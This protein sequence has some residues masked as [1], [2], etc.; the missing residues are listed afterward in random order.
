MKIECKLLIEILDKLSPIVK[1]GRVKEQ[2]PFI[3][4]HDNQLIAHS[5][6]CYMSIFLDHTFDNVV[7]PFDKTYSLLKGFSPKQN[8][9]FIQEG[10]KVKVNYSA[11]RKKTAAAIAMIEDVS[12]QYLDPFENTKWLPVPRDFIDG[13]KLCK[14]SLPRESLN[15]ALTNYAINKGV[16]VTS[17]DFRIS[18]YILDNAFGTTLSISAISGDVIISNNFNKWFQNDI[19]CID[20]ANDY[21]WT[22][23]MLGTAEY[24]KVTTQMFKYN[25]CFAV[26]RTALIKALERASIF[27]EGES[28]LDYIATLSTHTAIKGKP[29]FVVNANNDFGKISESGRLAHTN[30]EKELS[31]NPVYL[32]QIL[33]N[34]TE[35]TIEIGVDEYDRLIF[36]EGSYSHILA[37]YWET[38][39]E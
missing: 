10:N 26:S 6:D 37:T 21:A 34:L 25:D 31:I 36:N 33:K 35:K 19:N 38:N 27:A 16:I 17:D 32:L 20:F 39:K 14:I 28:E 1:A 29:Q 12:I 23:V 22:R 11:G 24:P 8:I 15:P 7:I 13:L 9:Q 2:N 4:L 5:E 18:H 30:V 3:L